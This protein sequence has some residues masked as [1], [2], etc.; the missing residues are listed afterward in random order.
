MSETRVATEGSSSQRTVTIAS[1]LFLLVLLP[2]QSQTPSPS[3]TLNRGTSRRIVVPTTPSGREN[4]PRF[5]VPHHPTPSVTPSPSS[6]P[7]LTDVI[8]TATLK[9]SPSPPVELGSQVQFE[10]V[11]PQ[12]PLAGWNLQYRFDF[13]DGHTTNW[14]PE[15]QAPH[16]YSS[17]APPIYPVYAEIGATYRDIVKPIRKINSSVQVVLRSSPTPSATASAR[18]TPS[19]PSYSPSP[20]ATATVESVTATPP[21]SGTNV[22]SPTAARWPPEQS[23]APPTS[24]PSNGGSAS[25]KGWWI[26]YIVSAGLAAAALFG[27]PK[28][29]KPTFHPHADWDAPQRPSQNVAI[30]YGLYF[31][32]NVSAGEVRL[33]T[34]G[35]R[36]ILRRKTQ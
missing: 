10:V 36:L 17:P 14:A 26:F 19:P 35:A 6:V 5:V 7:S 32:S 11:F 18:I 4:A 1:V 29:I 8:R 3:E 30:N 34:D 24:V 27:I 12:S 2:I 25:Q 9:V 20:T 15:R 31:H 21:G 16:T 23:S 13:G 28:L 33:Q 22:A